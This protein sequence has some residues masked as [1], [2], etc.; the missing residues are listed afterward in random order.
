MRFLNNREDAEDMLQEV[1]C[2]AFNKM[3]TFR[4]DS[5]FGAWLKR[6][7]VNK[8]INEL[9]RRKVSFSLIDEMEKFDAP[10]DVEDV[11]YHEN[12]KYTA[13]KIIEAM[14]QL[15]E[16]SKVVFSLF[17]LE[18]YEHSEISEILKISESTSKTQLMRAK[19]KIR[20]LIE[21]MKKSPS[22]NQMI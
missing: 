7:T 4:F 9:K 16:G 13:E 11:E 2:E 1:F 14:E 22:W 8:C 19:E 15:P 18:G 5:T 6:I 17:M 21:Q 20:I 10:E 12:V 3:H